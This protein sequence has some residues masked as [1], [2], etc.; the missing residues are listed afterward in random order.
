VELI[1]Q[2]VSRLVYLTNIVRSE[3]NA[4]LPE[5]AQR[6]IQKYSFLKFP[7]A[8]DLQKDTQIF[9]LGRFRDTQ[10]NELSVYGDGVIAAGRCS[11]KL[12]QA[13]LSDLFNFVEVEYGYRQSNILDP[14]THFESGLLVRSA[15]DLTSAIAPPKR[16]TTLIN[17]TL[18]K[19]NDAEYLAFGTHFETDVRV[20]NRRR[21]PV[22]FSLERRLG[23][24]FEKNV[25]YSQAPLETDDH[26]ALLEGI[27][28]LAE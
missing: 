8:D 19:N 5:L 25:F 13:F 27:E 7:N 23:I 16:V 6:V 14:E 24:P 26:F 22:R 20:P 28:S 21:R 18:R 12:L 10:I 1:S 4:Y 3:G 11:T 15:K 17:Q 2:E 9:S